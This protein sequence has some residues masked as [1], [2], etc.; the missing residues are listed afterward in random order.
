VIVSIILLLN[1]GTESEEG[2]DKREEK[3]KNFEKP[4]PRGNLAPKDTPMTHPNASAGN[5][6]KW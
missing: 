6:A 4:G 5:E 3:N 1:K 2:S